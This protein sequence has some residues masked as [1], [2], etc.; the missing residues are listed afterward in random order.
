MPTNDVPSRTRLLLSARKLFAENGYESTS[1]ASIARMAGTSESQ[2]IK[3]F[4]GK[5]SLLDAIFADGWNTLTTWLQQ[6]LP[7]TMSPTERLRTIPRLMFEALQRDPELRQLLLLEGRRIRKEGRLATLTDGFLGFVKLVDATLADMR[8]AG[9]LR[10]D[11]NPQAI[12][13][14]LIGLTEGALRDQLL[15]E[16]AGNPSE[17]T[18]ENIGSLVDALVKSVS[19]T[20]ATV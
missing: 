9:E 8:S 7:P 12:R 16:R 18:P 17:F 4:G 20:H 15:A 19:A 10:E 1:T 11:L 2:L 3:H 6:Q 13:S 14:A 5:A